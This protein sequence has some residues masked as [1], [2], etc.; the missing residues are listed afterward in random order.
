[1]DQALVLLITLNAQ[2]GSPMASALARSILQRK[3]SSTAGMRAIS[4]VVVAAV[5]LLHV[6]GIQAMT[7]DAQHGSPMASAGTPSI[8][9]LKRSSTVALLVACAK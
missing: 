8:H 6:L 4:V 5:A 2:H 7:L 3:N 9:K 1:M